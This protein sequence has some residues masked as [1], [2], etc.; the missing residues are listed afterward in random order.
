MFSSWSSSAK[1]TRLQPVSLPR[2]LPATF[3]GPGAAALPLEVD[4]QVEVDG[5]A[6]GGRARC[7]TTPTGFLTRGLTHRAELVG[8]AVV[9]YR[10]GPGARGLDLLVSSWPAATADLYAGAPLAAPRRRR[11][12]RCA[13]AAAAPAGTAAAPAAAP[14]VAAPR[15][16]DGYLPRANIMARIRGDTFTMVRWARC[17][18]VGAGEPLAL[19]PPA[20]LEPAGG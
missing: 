6:W 5:V 3:F 14:A 19:L 4:L 17:G 15:A 10:R 16:G 11:W 9:G 1:Q 13:A 2:F 20:S 12:R 8:A 7:A 18:C